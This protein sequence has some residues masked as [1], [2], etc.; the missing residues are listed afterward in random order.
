[1]IQNF[2]HQ[3][4]NYLQNNNSNANVSNRRNIRLTENKS[5]ITRLTNSRT[6]SLMNHEVRESQSNQLNCIENLE[7]D[8]A[9]HVIPD[10]RDSNFKDCNRVDWSQFDKHIDT[11]V[12]MHYLN[13]GHD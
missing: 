7:N 10:S 12:L 6:T 8:N 1:M 4:N 2:E 11:A 5:N 9:N 3:L 13:S